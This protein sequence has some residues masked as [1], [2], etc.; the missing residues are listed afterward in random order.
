MKRC[1]Q[2]P[3]KKRY[4]TERDAETVILLLNNYNLHP[5][6]CDA[7]NGWHLSSKS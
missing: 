5:Y 1:P 3:K 7:C 6:H 4:A 2:Y